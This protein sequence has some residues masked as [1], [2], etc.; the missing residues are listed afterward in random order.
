M[1]EISLLGKAYQ[2]QDFILF[3]LLTHWTLVTSEAGVNYETKKKRSR[4][5]R[6]S[7]KSLKTF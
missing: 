2:K 4:N 1:A 3:N 7:L 6:R 5:S